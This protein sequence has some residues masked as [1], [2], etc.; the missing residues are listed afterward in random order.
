MIRLHA[1]ELLSRRDAKKLLDRVGAENPELV[2][3]LV[4]KLLSPWL[5]QPVLQD[6]PHKRVPIRDGVSILGA[7]REVASITEHPAWLTEY[8]GQA[9]RRMVVNPYGDPSGDLPVYLLGPTSEPA[10]H[11][12]TEHTSHLNLAPQRI[13]GIQER[14]PRAMGSPETPVMG[15]GQL[16][17]PVFSAADRGSR[18][19]PPDVPVTQRESTGLKV[20]GLGVIE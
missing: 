2:E 8:A 1:H 16:G 20:V 10:V 15:C 3:D 6:L 18:H 7:L 9:S 12:A 11:S 17:F 14:I 13:R 19:G 5:M 4:P